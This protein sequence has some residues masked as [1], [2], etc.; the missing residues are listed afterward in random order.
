MV[1]TTFRKLV[2][3]AAVSAAMLVCSVGGAAEPTAA[4]LKVPTQALAS[5]VMNC[6]DHHGNLDRRA[7]HHA[8]RRD[9]QRVVLALR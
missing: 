7:C 2:T 4:D 3:V 8:G 6:R 1:A 9:P 5:Y